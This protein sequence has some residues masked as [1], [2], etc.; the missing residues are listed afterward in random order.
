[1]DDVADRAVLNQMAGMVVDLAVPDTP[2]TPAI[3]P[4]TS[5]S[6][7]TA[8]IGNADA[9]G[10][11]TTREP[12]ADQT[13][14]VGEG[15]PAEEPPPAGDGDPSPGR[16]VIDGSVS[17]SADDSPEDASGRESCVGDSGDRIS[18]DTRSEGSEGSEETASGGRA[19]KKE[20][21]R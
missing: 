21:T 13:S 10:D 5:S 14:P 19:E 20:D 18:G 16:T 11:G 1:M 8:V 7:T 12:A 2:P 15:N 4:N 9:G 17:S 6:T 3:A